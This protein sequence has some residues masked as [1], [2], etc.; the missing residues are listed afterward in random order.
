VDDG[1]VVL[2]D[3]HALGLTQVLQGGG[4]QAHAD[5]FAD[6]GTAGEDGD[7]LQ[8]GLATITK[9]RGLDRS[10]L[11]DAAHVVDDQGR[12]RFA[13]N[14]LGNNHQR[15]A[16]LGYCFQHRQHLADVGDLLVDQQDVGVFQLGR[17]GVGLVHEVRGQV[18]T[19]ELH[20]L[21][22]GQLV[23][24]TGTFLDSDHAFLADAVHGFGNDLADGLIGVGGDGAYL[25]DGLGVGA[26]LGQVLQL[27]NHGSGGLVDTA[28]QIHRVHAGGNSLQTFG[29]DGLGQNGSSG[30]TVTGVIVGAGSN[31]LDQLRTHVLEAVLQ[32]DFLGD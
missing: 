17:H 10:N 20:A 24:Q 12:Q 3:L 6:H 8:H 28:L 14:V 11:D 1:G 9:A 32:L 29:N 31:V 27:G 25:G 2:V 16:G 22:H 5:F 7:V 19:V 13:F 26:G 21:D 23:L 15:T 18:A 30:G 4:L